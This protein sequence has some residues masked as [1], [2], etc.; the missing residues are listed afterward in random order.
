MTGFTSNKSFR[1]K[2][3]MLLEQGYEICIGSTQLPNTPKYEPKYPTGKY[4][5]ECILLID[6]KNEMYPVEGD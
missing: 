4:T 2:V 1:R 5:R 6:D 3:D